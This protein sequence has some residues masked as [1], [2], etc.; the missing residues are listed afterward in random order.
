MAETLGVEQRDD[1]LS[2]LSEEQRNFLIHNMTR[3]RR[4]IFAQQM[5][6]AKGAVIPEE[7]DPEDIEKYLDGWIYT[8][9]TDAGKVS[10]DLLC[11]CG[12]QLRY[13]HQVQHKETGQ[14]M[15]FGIKHLG[16][17][18]GLDPKIVALIMK[19]FQ[20]LDYELDEILLK[21]EDGWRLDEW[22]FQDGFE[23]PSDIQAHLELNLPLLDRQVERL[24]RKLRIY[25]EQMQTERAAA[26]RERFARPVPEN[27]EQHV[28]ENNT[29]LF[30]GTLFEDIISAPDSIERS[31]AQG[32][33][34]KG[35][36]TK[37]Q[38]DLKPIV[39]RELQKGIKSVRVIT[40]QLQEAAGVDRRRYSTGKLHL[41]VPVCIYLDELVHSGQLR[42]V[43]QSMEDREYEIAN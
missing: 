42:L 12:H 9:Y 7:A 23:I 27:F 32:R 1:Y 35:H 25:M 26:R 31:S 30:Q 40:E 8:G 3:S 19:G 22:F 14:I 18:L 6:K 21:I 41:Y 5:A 13:Q 43:H 39:W 34:Y 20:T 38:E 10:P 15:H 16:D 29:S 33:Y 11:E 17:H 37:V 28:S 24:R 2:R 4:T 36:E